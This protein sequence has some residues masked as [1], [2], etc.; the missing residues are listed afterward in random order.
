[1]EQTSNQTKFSSQQIKLQ[2]M[3]DFSMTNYFKIDVIILINLK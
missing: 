3:K 2:N 1:M